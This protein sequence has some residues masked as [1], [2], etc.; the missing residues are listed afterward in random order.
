MSLKATLSALVLALS[1]CAHAPEISPQQLENKV[2]VSEAAAKPGKTCSQHNPAYLAS[3]N[4]I[5]LPD[6]FLKYL[7]K[8]DIFRGKVWD[9]AY[10]RKEFEGKELNMLYLEKGRKDAGTGNLEIWADDLVIFIGG[11]YHGGYSL[12]NVCFDGRYSNALHEK[13]EFKDFDGSLKIE[14]EAR[15]YLERLFKEFKYVE[16]N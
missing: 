15:E 16:E 4:G 3:Y 13:V 9:T 7:Q 10:V 11:G 14:A 8:N 2:S 6:S 12:V 5:A 1:A